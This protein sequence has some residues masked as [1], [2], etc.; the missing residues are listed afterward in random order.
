MRPH[1]L[2]ALGFAAILLAACAEVPTD[3]EE[4]AEFEQTNDP[5]EPMN[6]NIFAF[7]DFLDVHVME[8][9]ARTYHNN[10]PQGV[11]DAIHRFLLN[12]K[13][14][15]VA[16]NEVLQGKFKAASDDLG[17]FLINTTFGAVGLWDVAADAGGPKANDTDI[18]LTLGTWGIGEGPYLVLPF[19]GPSNP[20]DTAGRVGDFFADPVNAAITIPDGTKWAVDTRTGADVLDTRTQL[21]GP[22]A[23]LKRS[24]LDYYASV[25]SLYRQRR[26]SA[27]GQPGAQTGSADSNNLP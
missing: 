4:R 8:P 5:L 9:V 25:R 12:L 6:R 1:L 17:R 3:P 11:Q 27:L 16:G 15:Y 23:D 18:G 19:F 13:A 10:V 20:R 22:V 7:N 24:S 14:P 26:R 21:L 2:L